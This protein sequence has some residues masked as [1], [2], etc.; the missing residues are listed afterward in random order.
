[1]R[2]K[3]GCIHTGGKQALQVRHPLQRHV[4]LAQAT[5]RGKYQVAR[6]SR[7]RHAPGRAVPELNLQPTYPQCAA[8]AVGFINGLG[9][10]L[11]TQA[12][13]IGGLYIERLHHHTVA[14]GHGAYQRVGGRTQ[15]A[16]QRV[17]AWH[18]IKP[19]RHAPQRARAHH[20]RQRHAHGMGR[21]HIQKVRWSEYSRR[22]FS[23]QARDALRQLP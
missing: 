12:Q 2:R 23:H 11:L 18:V 21:S 8:G 17:T 1:M 10:H 9:H 4:C 6:F 13:Q 3:N 14:P 19:A 20:A 7:C 15:W 16:Q 22:L 5:Q